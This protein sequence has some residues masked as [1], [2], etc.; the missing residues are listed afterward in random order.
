[1]DI[2]FNFSRIA[3]IAY[4]IRGLKKGGSALTMLIN[5]AFFETAVLFQMSVYNVNFL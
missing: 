4:P 2:L 3:A 5:Q 1:M